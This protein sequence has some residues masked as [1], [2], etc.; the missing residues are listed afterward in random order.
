[1]PPK[2][3]KIKQSN[4]VAKKQDKKTKPIKC[5][6]SWPYQCSKCIKTFDTKW[7]LKR[8]EDNV[9]GD[10]K[11]LTCAICQRSFS[12]NYGLKRHKRNQS[13]KC[14]ACP[15]SY[16]TKLLLKTHVEEEH[17]TPHKVLYVLPRPKK[18]RWIVKLEKMKNLECFL[19]FSA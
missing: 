8:H 17:G 4:I 18:G 9:H 16:C 12:N 3:S 19:N 2:C 5:D 10:H 7:S 13:Y 15:K 11:P 6:I 1:M 14:V